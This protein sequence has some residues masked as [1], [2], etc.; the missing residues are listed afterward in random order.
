MESLA[1]GHLADDGEAAPSVKAMHAGLLV[2]SSFVLS[3]CCPRRR[4]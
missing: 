2:R 3:S 4:Q 1:F